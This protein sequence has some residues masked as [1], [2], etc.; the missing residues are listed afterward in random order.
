MSYFH[1]SA[2]IVLPLP[3]GLEQKLTLQ[4]AADLIGYLLKDGEL[5]NEN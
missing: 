1:H 4:D 2:P 5:K 3:D